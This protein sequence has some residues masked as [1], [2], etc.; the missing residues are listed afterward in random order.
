MKGVGERPPVSAQRSS[1]ESCEVTL[2]L[3]PTAQ[4]SSTESWEVTLLLSPT[5]ASL[6]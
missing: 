5:S 3:S 6:R 4:R 2:L 1:T